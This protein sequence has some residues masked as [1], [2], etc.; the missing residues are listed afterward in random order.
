MLA[1]DF[2]GGIKVWDLQA[3]CCITSLSYGGAQWERAVG[4]LA[5]LPAASDSSGCSDGEGPAPDSSGTTLLLACGQ[6]GR[7]KVWRLQLTAAEQA[8][9]STDP[10]QAGQGE[11]AASSDERRATAGSL[12]A[13]P[14]TAALSAPG[15]RG[16]GRPGTTA[17]STAGS[18]PRPP[19]LSC[20]AAPAVELP[21]ALRAGDC[22][23]AIAVDAAGGGLLTGDSSGHVRV[24]DVCSLNLS[25][26][27]AARASLRQASAAAEIWCLGPGLAN[28]G[29]L[30]GDYIFPEPGWPS[31]ALP[32]ATCRWGSG[33]RGSVPS[34]A[35]SCCRTA[36][37]CWWP[38]TIPLCPSGRPRCGACC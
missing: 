23:T 2:E 7:I 16:S 22:V 36:A 29:F 19:P 4:K 38:A 37:C 32:A 28:A 27:T 3:G 33:V 14:R 12:R 15:S 13:R 21:A 11:A 9:S 17:C 20:E 24:W 25:S 34:S 26:A 35:C 5:F 30:D 10:Q 18:S 8:A 31:P 6:D 1:G